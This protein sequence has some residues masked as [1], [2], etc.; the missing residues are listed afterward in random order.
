M[1]ALAAAARARSTIFVRGQLPSVRRATYS[2]NVS[3]SW[4]QPNTRLPEMS[5]A[6]WVLSSNQS[7]TFSVPRPAA[8]NICSAAVGLR[9]SDGSSLNRTSTNASEV[10]VAMA[11]SAPSAGRSP[12]EWSQTRRREAR[13]VPTLGWVSA[14]RGCAGALPP[15]CGG[16]AVCEASMNPAV[17]TAPEP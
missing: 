10:G 3:G 16:T 15:R 8:V 6:P 17:W 5:T 13:G 9:G 1:P 4:Y 7:T 14:D 12:G 11:C 2:A